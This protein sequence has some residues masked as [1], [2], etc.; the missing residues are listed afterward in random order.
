M[1]TENITRAGGTRR[2]PVGADRP[3]VPPGTGAF[4]TPDTGECLSPRGTVLTV[5]TVAELAALAGATAT[6][7]RLR[8]R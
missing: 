4:L 6:P 2:S 8:T 1:Q 7:T 5:P 3:T